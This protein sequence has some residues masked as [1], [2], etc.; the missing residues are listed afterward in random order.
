MS[1]A[2]CT[3]ATVCTVSALPVLDKLSVSM[4]AQQPTAQRRLAQ[5]A[6]GFNHSVLS[7]LLQALPAR[8]AEPVAICQVPPGKGKLPVESSC[9]A[10][11]CLDD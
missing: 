11:Y 4:F 6:V 7:T 3:V 9:P 10:K 5:P 2:V 1:N 8:L